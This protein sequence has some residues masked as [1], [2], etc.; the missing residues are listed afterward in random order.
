MSPAFFNR[1][2]GRLSYEER[3]A[4]V[5]QQMNIQLA[6][7]SVTAAYL[8]LWDK[9]APDSYLIYYLFQTDDQ[10][11]SAKQTGLKSQILQQTK[12]ALIQQGFSAGFLQKNP[13][14]IA[15]VSDET[16]KR[17]YEGNH[18]YYFR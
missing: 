15:F 6:T 2:F 16:V 8:T 9:D 10:L 12:Q 13:G 18:Y 3:I 5:V 11:E 14:F 7:H 17:D 1:I 4:E